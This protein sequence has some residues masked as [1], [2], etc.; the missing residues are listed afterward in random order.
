M[1]EKTKN[2]EPT[3]IEAQDIKLV[4]MVT[5]DDDKAY[6]DMQNVN[7]DFWKRFGNKIYE[8]VEEITAFRLDQDDNRFAIWADDR[9]VGFVGYSVKG[10]PREA[11]IGIS[12]DQNSTG[13]GYATKSFRALTDFAKSQFDRV[14]A[15]VAPDNINSV[16]MLKRSGYQTTG[17]IVERDWGKALVFE[18]PD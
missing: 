6:F 10:H 17:E 4:Q 8:S 11:E 18:A 7:L 15:E 1:S 12:L 14:Y 2:T 5:Q 13:H 16:E 3:I 9:L